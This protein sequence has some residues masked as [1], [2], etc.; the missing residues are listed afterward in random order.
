MTELVPRRFAAASAAS[1]AAPLR[2]GNSH[3][4]LDAPAF[5]PEY[6]DRVVLT[7][8]P[9][10]FITNVHRVV[11][12]LPLGSCWTGEAIRLQCQALGITPRHHN[13][14]GRAIRYCLSSGLLTETGRF[15][16]MRTR[17][18]HGRRNPEYIRVSHS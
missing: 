8:T 5:L 1:C 9:E 16:R 11:H 14:W 2:G 3:G 12:A 15:P 4:G 6:F 17:L 10:D 7:R 18:A 13:A